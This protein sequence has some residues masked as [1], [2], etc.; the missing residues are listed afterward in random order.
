MVSAVPNA[1]RAR[2]SDPTLFAQR[3]LKQRQESQAQRQR[4]SESSLSFRLSLGQKNPTRFD[5]R[6]ATLHSP[7]KYACRVARF[8]I[9]V[10]LP[11]LTKEKL[12]DHIAQ[13]GSIVPGAHGIH[14]VRFWSAF[15]RTKSCAACG[16]GSV[17]CTGRRD[18]GSCTGHR[19]RVE[20]S[21]RGRGRT[22]PGRHL[23][24]ELNEKNR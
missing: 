2:L 6:D 20:H 15:V 11:T 13:V 22:Q 17:A 9:S 12:N 5:R 14:F 16:G 19:D 1:S 24:P 4:K 10:W 23:R 8:F 18:G 3:W 7:P 21:E